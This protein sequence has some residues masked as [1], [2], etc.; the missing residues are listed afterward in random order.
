MKAADETGI[1]TECVQGNP[2]AAVTISLKAV[3]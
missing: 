3:C 2:A 1:S